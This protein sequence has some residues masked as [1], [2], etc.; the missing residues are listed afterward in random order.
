MTEGERVGLGD[1]LALACLA[2]QAACIHFA[3]TAPA[4]APA[5]SAPEPAAPPGTAGASAPYLG[6]QDAVDQL[7]QR[8]DT[9][10]FGACVGLGL[11]YLH[12]SL[13]P[14]DRARA[15]GLFEKACDGGNRAGCGQLEAL[16]SPTPELASARVKVFTSDHVWVNGKLVSQPLN[17]R[18][19]PTLL[20][21]LPVMF[22]KECE[23]GKQQGC[24]ALGLLYWEG[25]GVARDRARAEQLLQSACDAGDQR[26]CKILSA[27]EGTMGAPVLDS[28]RGSSP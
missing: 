5:A 11:L 12:G 7:R 9:G 27:L 25:N 24:V 21:S 28:T 6:Y 18:V 22:E 1:R 3:A 2:G 14:S 20:S 13:V 17:L 26:G 8:C 16:R 15:R 10:R 19:L 23:G 4:S